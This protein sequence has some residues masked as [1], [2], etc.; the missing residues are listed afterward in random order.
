MVLSNISYTEEYS[1]LT[2]GELSF[3]LYA[4]TNM[5]ED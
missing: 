4:I 2:E 1:V 5:A 3:T